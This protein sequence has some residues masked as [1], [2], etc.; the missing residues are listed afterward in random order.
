MATATDG[1][2]ALGGLMAIGMMFYVAMTLY[3]NRSSHYGTGRERDIYSR[4]GFSDLSSHLTRNQLTTDKDDEL[5]NQLEED[6]VRDELQ[7]K[8]NHADSS[9]IDEDETAVADAKAAKEAIAAESEIEAINTRTAAALA[10]IKLIQKSILEFAKKEYK[11]EYSISFLVAQIDKMTVRIE[12]IVTNRRFNQETKNYFDKY[13]K[14]ILSYLEGEIKNEK[15]RDTHMLE[16]LVPTKEAVR[17][18]LD[19]FKETSQELDR[20]K[21]DERKAGKDHK[22]AL[23]DLEA[24]TSDI[25]S[26]LLQANKGKN[27]EKNPEEIK[28]LEKYVKQSL[29]N[30]QK[31]LIILISFSDA[32]LWI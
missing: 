9:T 16:F 4:S 28:V 27:D 11:A 20:L 30:N 13:I 31:Y 29:K 10:A 25:R 8:K 17:G 18:M 24:R 14:L 19:M 5:I 6:L 21:K 26:D 2:L 3:K 12:T 15:L 32:I 1:L 7:D 22:Q 23:K